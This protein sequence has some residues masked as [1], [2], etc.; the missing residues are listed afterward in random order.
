MKATPVFG[1]AYYLEFAPGI[2]ED[3]SIIAETGL[4]VETPFDHYDDVIKIIDSSALSTGIENKYYAPGVGE[5]T[6]A[7]IAPDGSITRKVDLYRTG[8]VGARIPMTRTTSWRCPSF[9][10]EGS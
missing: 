3:E 10:R 4:S 2:A 7:E 1:P 6:E 8:D 9:T 5:I